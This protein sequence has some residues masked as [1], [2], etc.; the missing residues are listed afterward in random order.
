MKYKPKDQESSESQESRS[1]T[2]KKVEMIREIDPEYASS[3]IS[4]EDSSHEY[5]K[6]DNKEIDDIFDIVINDKDKQFLI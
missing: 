2:E 6:M 4:E 1:F 5:D 3:D